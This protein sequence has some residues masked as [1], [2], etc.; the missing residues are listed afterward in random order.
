[1]HES[2]NGRKDSILKTEF[3]VFHRFCV[4]GKDFD[5]QSET[6]SCKSLSSCRDSI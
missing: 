2:C 6:M 1:M 3:R 4:Q 5:S